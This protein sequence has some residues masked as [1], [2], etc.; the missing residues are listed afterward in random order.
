MIYEYD[1]KRADLRSSKVV[2]FTCPDRAGPEE[3]PAAISRLI[4]NA[5][6]IISWLRKTIQ[7]PSKWS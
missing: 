1:Q 4:Y 2:C 5:A 6:A 7:K 3:N